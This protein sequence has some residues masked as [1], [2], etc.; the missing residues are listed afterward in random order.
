M[1]PCE[2]EGSPT[3][4]LGRA[5][6]NKRHRVAKLLS[7]WYVYWNSRTPQ[8]PMAY[9]PAT[10]G[11]P[12]PS[13][14]ATTAEPTGGRFAAIVRPLTASGACPVDYRHAA[15]S[16]VPNVYDIVAR[17]KMPGICFHNDSVELLYAEVL[18]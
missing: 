8:H 4:D 7:D 3:L 15:G 12:P 9:P 18:A 11:L 10:P 1:K 16:P 2:G 14:A 6:R 5:K 13:K 17:G